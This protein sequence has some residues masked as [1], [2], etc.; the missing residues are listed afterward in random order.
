MLI[1]D[2]KKDYHGIKSSQFLYNCLNT[3]K[4][5]KDYVSPKP[6]MILNGYLIDDSGTYQWF[7]FYLHFKPSNISGKLIIELTNINPRNPDEDYIGKLLKITN[8]LRLRFIE[9]NLEFSF[10]TPSSFTLIL[11][12]YLNMYESLV[13]ILNILFSKKHIAMSLHHSIS[14]ADSLIKFPDSMAFN[15]YIR[16]VIVE[17]NNFNTFENMIEMRQSTF[18]QFNGASTRVKSIHIQRSDMLDIRCGYCD[19]NLGK[20]KKE[21]VQLAHI[22]CKGYDQKYVYI[23]QVYKKLIPGMEII[24]YLMPILDLIL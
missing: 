7:S 12:D 3:L 6:F 18:A 5:T 9:N 20:Q 21:L 19:P 15:Q 14:W 16:S 2:I 23:L 4:A 11:D 24:D 13:D 10:D 17:I 22:D 1:E 8:T